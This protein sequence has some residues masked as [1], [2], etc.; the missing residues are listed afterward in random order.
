MW[1]LLRAKFWLSLFW[2]GSQNAEK[3]I[4]KSILENYCLN[5]N[6]PYI[7]FPRIPTFFNIFHLRKCLAVCFSKHESPFGPLATWIRV[8]TKILQMTSVI[9]AKENDQLEN[10][11]TVIYCT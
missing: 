1:P 11:Y 4:E 5:E 3:H 8:L 9:K 7:I 10:C 2:I 6:N